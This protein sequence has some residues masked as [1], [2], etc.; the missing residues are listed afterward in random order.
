MFICISSSISTINAIKKINER[1]EGVISV[2]KTYLEFESIMD[3]IFQGDSFF[4]LQSVIQIPGL[5]PR[6]QEVYNFV[7]NGGTFIEVASVLGMRRREYYNYRSIILKKMNVKSFKKLIE[8]I[9]KIN[10]WKNQINASKPKSGCLQKKCL[11]L[12]LKSQGE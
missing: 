1:V 5:T 3:R 6:E 8:N 7:I 12:L 10:I 4:E 11:I 2:K 9:K